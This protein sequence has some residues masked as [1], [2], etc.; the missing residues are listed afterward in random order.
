MPGND[1]PCERDTPTASTDRY[2]DLRGVACPMNFVKA[3]LALDKMP[4]GSCLRLFLDDGE[5]IESVSSSM[6]AEGHAIE[7]QSRLPEGHWSLEVR[8]V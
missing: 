2:L 1:G 5:P 8:K 6:K 7:V 4:P 3:K